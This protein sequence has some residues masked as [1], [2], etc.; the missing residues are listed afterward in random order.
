MIGSDG[1]ISVV[2]CVTCPC[3]AGVVACFERS[4]AKATGMST[5]AI[6]QGLRKRKTAKRIAW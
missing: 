4:V 6:A 1:D 3:V 2:T 5:V